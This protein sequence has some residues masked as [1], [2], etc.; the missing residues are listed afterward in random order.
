[1]ARFI[2]ARLFSAILLFFAVTLFV[3]I[4]FFVMPQPQI[5]QLG[6]GSGASEYDVHNALQLH[7]TAAGP[8]QWAYHLLLPWFVFA[9]LYA[10]IYARMIRASVME[11][12]DEEYVHTARAKAP[13][14]R[15][16]FATT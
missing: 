8:T 14:R 12:I 9:F 15:R 4:V 6:R 11:T 16:C 3:F 13:P 5:R 1:M 10:A 7:G 2:V